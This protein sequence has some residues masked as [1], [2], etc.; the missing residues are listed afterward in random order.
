M[1][2]IGALYVT[3]VHAGRRLATIKKNALENRQTPTAPS[4]A[5]WG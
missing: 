1:T 2:P 4:S 3:A 5:M